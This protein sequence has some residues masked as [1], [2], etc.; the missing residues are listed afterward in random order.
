MRNHDNAKKEWTDEELKKLYETHERLLDL[1]SLFCFVPRAKYLPLGPTRYLY[2]LIKKNLREVQWKAS[3]LCFP[4]LSVHHIVAMHIWFVSDRYFRCVVVCSIEAYSKRQW[5]NLM[6]LIVIF[7]HHFFFSF[8]HF[9][10][11]F[12][13]FLF[14]MHALIKNFT[15]CHLLT[16]WQLMFCSHKWFILR[17]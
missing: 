15:S 4:F 13:L 8:L 7:S 6:D 11:W 1:V 14:L 2:Y 17:S 10:I 9:W 3:Y 12:Y 5:K 16:V